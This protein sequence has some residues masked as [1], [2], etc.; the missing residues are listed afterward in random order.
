MKEPDPNSQAQPSP[1]R[2][3]FLQRATQGGLLAGAAAVGAFTPR[4]ASAPRDTQA[5]AADKQGYHESEHTRQYYR[6]LGIF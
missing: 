5:A 3:G 1:S 4:K 2:R 6:S